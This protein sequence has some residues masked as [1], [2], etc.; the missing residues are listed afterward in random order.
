MENADQQSDYAGGSVR[1]IRTMSACGLYRQPQ[2]K[3]RGRSVLAMSGLLGTFVLLPVQMIQLPLQMD[4]VDFWILGTLSVFWLG[5]IFGH[6]TLNISLPYVVALW[7]ILAGSFVGTFAAVDQVGSC[8]V[9]LKELYLFFAFITV[10]TL[11]ARTS[12]SSF[13][14]VMLTWLGTVVLH[15]ALI[16][17]EFLV[18]ELYQ[19]L[20]G[21]AGQ[22]MS[23]QHFRPSGLFFSP[24]AGNA[25]KAAV[26]QLLGFVPLL[27]AGTSR[28]TASVLGLVL[29][30]S[31]LATGSM[32][33]T[34]AFT[35]GLIVSVVAIA[36]TGQHLVFLTK[37]L[38]RSLLVAA[39]LSGILLLVLRDNEAYQAHFQSILF[40]R[41][42][43]SSAGRFSLWQRGLDTLSESNTFVWG[44]G[45]EN[46]RDVDVQEKQLHNDL[47]AF[48]VERGIL[49]TGGLVLLA[50]IA[51]C[52][53]A[54]LLHFSCQH[55]QLE[56][57]ATVVF[58]GAFAAILFVSL[59]H[60][61][62][63]CREIW[64]VLATQESLLTRYR[65]GSAATAR[66]LD[67]FTLGA[68][69]EHLEGI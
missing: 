9:I 4:A 35:V 48:S 28:R 60:Q 29:L 20:S 59:T 19:Y 64:L 51:V 55:S 6:H 47:L 54:Y 32:G 23:Y 46:F 36:A 10:S 31:I 27:L 38:V 52:R 11:L 49:G 7:L 2:W 45:P 21:L 40:G 1:Q 18:P 22:E 8:V 50:G 42:E 34:L 26:F 3:F 15:G 5:F 24:K 17:A 57:I 63:H 53:A 16:V 65:A 68:A 25:N 43:K 56:G 30:A 66:E 69:G 44:I 67:A 12:I 13:R 37:L 33:T 14:L 61:V 58:L 41:A 62:F 39:V